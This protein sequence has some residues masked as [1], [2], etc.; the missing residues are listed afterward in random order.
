MT[1]T[2]NDGMP[3]TWELRHGLNPN[4]ASDAIID[5]DSD[6]LTNLQEYQYYL[7]T[8]REIDQRTRIQTQTGTTTTPR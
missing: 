3:D 6:S 1:D 2:D 7:N 5:S 8:Q 4:N